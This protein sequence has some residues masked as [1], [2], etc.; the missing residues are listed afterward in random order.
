MTLSTGKRVLIVNTLFGPYLRRRKIVPQYLR[1]LGFAVSSLYGASGISA[2]D[3]DALRSKNIVIAT[4]RS[5]I[6][7]FGTMQI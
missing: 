7:R 4:P 1:S 6:L 3:E 5:S 2:G